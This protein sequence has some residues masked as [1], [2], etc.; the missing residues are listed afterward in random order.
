MRVSHFKYIGEYV[1]GRESILNL[2]VQCSI[3]SYIKRCLQ[4]WVYGT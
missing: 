3:E 4:V 1:G 2:N